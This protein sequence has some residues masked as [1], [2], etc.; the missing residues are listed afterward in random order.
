MALAWLAQGVL[1]GALAMAGRTLGGKWR[2]VRRHVMMFPGGTAMVTYLALEFLPVAA[3]LV[4]AAA[5]LGMVGM[6][7]VAG[8]LVTFGALVGFVAL[9][10]IGLLLPNLAVSERLTDYA[11][12]QQPS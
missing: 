7:A 3:S 9:C 2:R 6:P 1:L 5:V 10:L 12:P 4:G 11:S 8:I